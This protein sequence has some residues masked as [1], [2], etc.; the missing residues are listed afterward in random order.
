MRY[1]VFLHYFRFNGYAS[2]NLGRSSFDVEHFF[3]A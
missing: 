2:K 1:L 3:I